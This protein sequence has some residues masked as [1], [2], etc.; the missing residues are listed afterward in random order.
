MG[1]GVRPRY[2]KCRAVSC[3]VG[4]LVCSVMRVLA[5]GVRKP[6]TSVEVWKVCLTFSGMSQ[7]GVSPCSFDRSKKLVSVGR[8]HGRD[9]GTLFFNSVRMALKPSVRHPF[10]FLETPK[11]RVK[12]G[13]FRC[14]SLEA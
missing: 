14:V 13:L 1:K 2:A 11:G 5:R 12:F 3:A 8:T 6:F 4:V 10:Q 9:H 7:F